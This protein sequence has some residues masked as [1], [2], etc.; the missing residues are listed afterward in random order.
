MIRFSD[1]GS[2]NGLM[3]SIKT[4]HYNLG[5]CH[6]SEP[7]FVLFCQLHHDSKCR[8]DFILRQ[9]GVSGFYAVFDGRRCY[10]LA[11]T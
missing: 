6:A 8:C 2:R 5:Q 9:A 7:E 3:R 10:C 4:R 11:T 1:E